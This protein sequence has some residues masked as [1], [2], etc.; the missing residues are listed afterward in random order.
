MR[1]WIVAVIAL[2]PLQ[3]LAATYVFTGNNYVDPVGVYTT[4]MRMTGWFST[5]EPLPANM[6]K[7]EIGPKGANLVTALSF[8]D[9]VFTW[10]HEN[11]VAAIDSD[12]LFSVSTD[13]DGNIDG[14]HLA[15][16]SPL[17]PHALDSPI[18]VFNIRSD[19]QV[20]TRIYN[21]GTCGGTSPNEVCSIIR[22][23]DDPP[24]GG[25]VDYLVLPISERPPT[26]SFVTQLSP[27]N[28]AEGGS[29]PIPTLSVPGLALLGTVM[30]LLGWRRHR[31]HASARR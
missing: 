9:G 23:P 19:T 30:A 2:A 6:P 12:S 28:G 22:F 15:L 21:L 24:P 18:N 13:A 7:T 31:T 4:D 17:P 5:A 10:T 26:G 25:Y 14:F 27:G 16:M 20:Y 1:R 8:S 3:A 29:N 11:S